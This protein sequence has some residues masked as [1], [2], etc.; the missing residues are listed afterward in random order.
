[1]LQED[2]TMDEKKLQKKRILIVDDEESL[3]QLVKL[4][5]E[6]TGAYE[7]FLAHNGEEGLAMVDKE[8]PDIIIL[9]VMMPGMNGF[10]VLQELRKPGVKWR[11]VIMLTGKGASSDIKKGY[12]LEA[13]HYITKPFRTKELL[14]G[15]ETMLSL[16]SRN[17]EEK[18]KQ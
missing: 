18:E 15:I 6:R 17:E 13:D 9:D 11:P 2:N 3:V 10:E 5:I 14:Q 1:M 12:N 8:D 7:V 4:N 16:F